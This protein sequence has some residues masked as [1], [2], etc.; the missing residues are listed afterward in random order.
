MDILLISINKQIRI[1]HISNQEDK[2][3]YT[4]YDNH[5]T[6]LDG[7]VIDLENAINNENAIKNVVNIIKNQYEFSQP[8]IYVPNEITEELLEI[9]QEADYENVQEKVQ[10]IS[11]NSS[12]KE[13]L[14]NELEMVY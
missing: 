1:L 14:E 11:S 9:I 4:I 7:G 3:D 2:I 6:L 8:Y 12:L 5:C 13:E 10:N